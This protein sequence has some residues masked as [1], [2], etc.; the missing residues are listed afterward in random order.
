MP[1]ASGNVLRVEHLVGG[2]RI[3]DESLGWQIARIQAM[4]S[5]MRAGRGIINAT[6]FTSETAAAD[7]MGLGLG[8]VRMAGKLPPRRARERSGGSTTTPDMISSSTRARASGRT[9]IA[10]INHKNSC[11]MDGD[12]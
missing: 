9:S 3:R 2:I 1:P 6:L 12:S 8:T 7:H 5:M 4:G 11:G 10:G